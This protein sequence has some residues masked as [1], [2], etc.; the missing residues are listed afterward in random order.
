[1]VSVG[2]PVAPAAGADAVAGLY[3]QPSLPASAWSAVRIDVVEELWGEGFV[4]PG[5][6]EALM[7][8]AAPL[9]L[10]DSS[11]VL[12]LGAGMGGGARLLAESFDAWVSGYE[13]DGELAALAAIR[14]KKIG[15]SAARRASVAVWD[16]AAPA[17]KRR[18]FHHA[19]AI[20]VIRTAAP[21]DLLA[22]SALALKPGG[23]F[24]VVQLVADPAL[25]PAD[26]GLLAWAGLEQR[27]AA[28]PLA[29]EITRVLVRLGFDVRVTE[30][31]SPRHMQQVLLGWAGLVGRLHG[32]K[33]APLHAAAIVRE[34][35]RWMRRVRLMQEGKLRLMRWH[36]IG[37]ADARHIPP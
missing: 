30:D 34:A 28:L 16:P 2:R 33:P 18:F 11:S 9:G 20:D 23:Q 37:R 21:H 4:T 7:R 27:P 8:L 24:V 1:M 3:V 29:D 22:A 12:L 26:P 10:S 14:L 36:G 6:A 15:G 25:D 32:P 13:A 5:G 35:E 17:F 31:I 19:L